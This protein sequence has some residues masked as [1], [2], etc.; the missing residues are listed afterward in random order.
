MAKP[1]L[2]GRSEHNGQMVAETGVSIPYRAAWVPDDDPERD[3]DTAS[4]LALRWLDAEASHSGGTVVLVTHSFDNGAGSQVLSRF[5]RGRNHLTTRSSSLPG[6]RGPVLA[7]VPTSEVLALAIARAQGSA[8]C[9]VESVSNPVRGWAM[10]TGAVNL[11]TG[12]TEVLDERLRQHLDRLKFYG[13]NGYGPKFDQDRARNVLDDL[14][15]D[16]LLNVDV[17]VSAL[18]ALNVSVRGQEKIRELAKR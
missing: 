5:T 12:E 4:A 9:V 3:W 2:T 6:V 15:T 8:L 1:A 13:N 7:Y 18:A 10:V 16:G 14:R 17:I 11:I